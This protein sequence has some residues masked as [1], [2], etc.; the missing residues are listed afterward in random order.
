MKS[1]ELNSPSNPKNDIFNFGVVIFHKTVYLHNYVNYILVYNLF[2]STYRNSI[3][4]LG[5]GIELKSDA[6]IYQ[7]MQILRK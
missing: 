1:C 5:F 7:K 2:K 4:I 6:N 3:D